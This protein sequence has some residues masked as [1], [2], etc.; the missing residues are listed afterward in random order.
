MEFIC[1]L[2]QTCFLISHMTG[3]T[4]AEELVSLGRLCEASADQ[5]P[6][7][8]THTTCYVRD[9][10]ADSFLSTGKVNVVWILQSWALSQSQSRD[11]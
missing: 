10:L 9:R 5:R 4:G 7:L 6:D 8:Q 11:S 1:Y 2:P 3:L